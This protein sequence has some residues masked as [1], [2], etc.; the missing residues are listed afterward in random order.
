V[1]DSSEIKLL[2]HRIKYKF[3]DQDLLLKALRHKSFVNEQG[4]DSVTS[5]QRLEFLGDAVIEL[6]VTENLYKLF[7][8]ADEGKLSV[9]RSRLVRTESLAAH[10]RE[11]GLGEFLT[12][13]RG[14]EHN[15]ERENPTV[16]EDAFESLM[17]A[18][19]LDS[20]YDKAA[21][22]V[23]NA[24]KVAIYNA[25]EDERQGV[26]MW[27]R[28]TALQIKL[29]VDGPANIVYKMAGTDGPP[30]ERTFTAE[31]YLGKKLLGTGS[32]TS[33]KEAEQVAAGNALELLKGASS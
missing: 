18:V 15:G 13:G 16:L 9:L 19:F 3:R 22:I 29:Q 10:A 12:L 1:I 24:M 4:L 17:G 5:N 25:V 8:E 32:G 11:I 7:P 26:G 20:S 33:K 23:Y 27:D 30:H 28:K 14:A 21:K 2:Q 6:T 31:V